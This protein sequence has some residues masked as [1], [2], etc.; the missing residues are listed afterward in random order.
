MYSPKIKEH[1]IPT[2]YHLS[3]QKRIPMTKLVN[4]AITEYLSKEEN[5]LRK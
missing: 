3:K 2:L 1:H 4:Q 5:Q